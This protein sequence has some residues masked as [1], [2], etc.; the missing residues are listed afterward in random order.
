MRESNALLDSGFHAFDSEF[1]ILYMFFLGG[2]CFLYSN[3]QWDSGF[4]KKNFP[5]F[6]FLKEKIRKEEILNPLHGGDTFHSDNI[7]QKTLLGR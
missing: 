7:E 1:L 6:L 5:G 3:R 2:T 4:H